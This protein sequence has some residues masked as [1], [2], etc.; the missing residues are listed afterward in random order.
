MNRFTAPLTFAALL[1]ASGLPVLAIDS[2]HG[3]AMMPKCAAGDPVVMVNMKTKKYMMADKT[4]TK[5]SVA[6]ESG[7]MDK[8][9]MKPHTAMM[10]KSK[11]DAMGAHMMK[12]TM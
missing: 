10:C 7:M 12:G 1:A 2:M 8:N 6:H 4:H 11:A 3:S 5:M 9:M